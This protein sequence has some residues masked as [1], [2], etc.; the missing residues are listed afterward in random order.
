MHH[1]KASDIA[2]RRPSTIERRVFSEGFPSVRAYFGHPKWKGPAD[3]YIS[4]AN[5]KRDV[6]EDDDVTFF[7]ATYMLFQALGQTLR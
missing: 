7:V 4:A 3:K 6:S 5:L 1:A 2:L